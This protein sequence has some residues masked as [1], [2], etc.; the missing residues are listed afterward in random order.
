[1]GFISPHFLS[2]HSTSPASSPPSPA[3]NGCLWM[4]TAMRTYLRRDV[5]Q[6]GHEITLHKAQVDWDKKVDKEGAHHTM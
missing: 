4:A 1:M 5:F 3:S 6:G 2:P